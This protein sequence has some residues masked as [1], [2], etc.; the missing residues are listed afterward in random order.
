[1]FRG[2]LVAAILAGCAAESDGGVDSGEGEERFWE[3]AFETQE[4]RFS[5]LLTPNPDPPELGDFVLEMQLARNSD[6]PDF[7]GALLVNA[8]VS[9]FGEQA[10]GPGSLG[11]AIEAEELGAGK[12]AASWV[13][14]H[15]GAWH[16]RMEIGAAEDKDIALFG[17]L[18]E[19]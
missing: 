8:G 15:P 18:V 11:G 3:M 7:D 14:A 2:A 6:N 10:S 12:Y 16:L 13:F 17:L 1:M 19:D 9:L 5:V 4:G